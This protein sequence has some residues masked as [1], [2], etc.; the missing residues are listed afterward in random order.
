MR[1]PSRWYRSFAASRSATA[2]SS[3]PSRMQRLAAVRERERPEG[4]EAGEVG[5]PEREVELRHRLLVGALLDV[6]RAAVR[7]HADQLEHVARLLRVVERAEVVRVVRASVALERGEHRQHG[8][9]GGERLRIARLRRDRER[10]R[11]VAATRVASPRS[12]CADARQASSSATSRGS[13]SSEARSYVASAS[14]RRPPRW[15]RRPVRHASPGAT[16]RVAR[17]AGRSSAA[18]RPSRRAPGAPRRRAAR[19]RATGASGGGARRRRARRR[20]RRAR[21]ASA[22]GSPAAA[23]AGAV[24]GGG[25]RAK[26]LLG[27]AV[28][29]EPACRAGAH[30]SQL[31][32]LGPPSGQRELAH[33]RAERVPAD[34]VA[35]EL[36]EEAAPGQRVQVSAACDARAPRRARP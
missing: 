36:D 5:E 25:Q 8:V 32:A 15:C 23:R 7:A 19:S 34:R 6:P 13:P 29:L 12:Q 35:L 33:R 20:P 3:R 27:L 24:A 18:P 17:G 14:S 30:P 16:R 21:A 22:R 26:C 10:A 2:S 1:E 4:R 28:R 11:R 9:R 31:G